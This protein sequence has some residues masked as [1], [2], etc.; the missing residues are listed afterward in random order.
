MTKSYKKMKRT[1]PLIRV[2][3]S[4]MDE[5]IIFLTKIRDHKLQVV[6]AMR[7]NQKQ[8]MDGVDRL[9][10]IRNSADRQNLEAL[11]RGLDV[12]KSKW[13]QLHVEVQN[14]ENMEKAQVA[15]VLLAQKE[16]K[17]VEKLKENYKSKF[18]QDLAQSEQKVQDEQTLAKYIRNQ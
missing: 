9:N 13:Y 4:Q 11:E 18:L 7:I 15:Q 6:E 2:R 17:K 12:V 10:N 1:E 3:K 5:Q 14:V 16:L 8:Y